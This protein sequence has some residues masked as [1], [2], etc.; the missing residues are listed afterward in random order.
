[1]PTVAVRGLPSRPLA[2]PPNR[3]RWGTEELVEVVGL[4]AVEAVSWATAEGPP[5]SRAKVRVE[6]SRSARG[7][8][9]ES[10]DGAAINS[11]RLGNAWPRRMPHIFALGGRIM[12]PKVLHTLGGP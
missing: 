9:G 3:T 2:V 6:T 5:D 12:Q 7:F 8:M 10:P 1:M 4:I 11:R